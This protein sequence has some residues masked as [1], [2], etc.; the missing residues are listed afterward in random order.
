MGH[1]DSSSPWNETSYGKIVDRYILSS[2][3]AC[4]FGVMM[5]SAGFVWPPN[6]LLKQAL[7]VNE[8]ILIQSQQIKFKI[9]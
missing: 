7:R 4:C 5:M 8:S 2:G 6:S 9:D 1:L 3:I